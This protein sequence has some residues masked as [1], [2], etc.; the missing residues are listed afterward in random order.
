MRDPSLR[1]EKLETEERE[2][3]A[4]GLPTSFTTPQRPVTPS[5][6]FQ[7]A[8]KADVAVPKT[9]IKFGAKFDP[10][11]YLASMGW[12]G[13]G[14]G[15]SGQG[16]VKPIEVQ[17]RPERAGIAYGGIKEKTSHAK[18]EARRRGE[19]GSSDQ[20]QRQR[21]RS[22]G[23]P[24]KAKPEA[25]AWTKASTPKSRKPKIEHRTYEEIIAE[26]GAL[27]TTH[28]TV[29]KIYDASSGV[30][31]EVEDLASALKAKRVPTSAAT[32]LPELQHNLRLICENNAQSLGALAREGAQL[33]QRRTWLT[34][35]RERA[36]V[37]KKEEEMS[38]QKV[39]GAL[40]VVKRFEAV[41]KRIGDGEVGLDGG[42]SVLEEFTPLIEQLQREYDEKQI[43]QLALDQAV[44]EAITPA[45]RAI[46]CGWKPLEQPR[47][48]SRYL[49]Q[50]KAL[51]P[52][53]DS[54]APSSSSATMTPFDAL[55]WTY[56]MPRVRTCLSTFS[57]RRPASAIDLVEAWRPVLARFMFDNIIDQLIV[58]RLSRSV[59]A[60]DA[61]TSMDAL[62]QI[63]F[64]WLAVLGVERL[65]EVLTQAKQRLRSALK[66]CSISQGPSRGLRDWS[67]LYTTAA[68]WEALLLS[69]LV[70]RLSAYL[71]RR[72]TISAGETQDMTPLVDVLKWSKVVGATVMESVVA[73]DFFAKWLDVLCAWLKS[74]VH[75]WVGM[76]EWYLFWRRWW[77]E[78][79]GG[80]EVGFAI[81]L[82]VINAALDMTADERSKLKT[83]PFAHTASTAPSTPSGMPIRTLPQAHVSLRD[84]LAERLA[85]HDLLLTRSSQVHATGVVGTANIWRISSSPTSRTHA[86]KSSLIYIHDHVVFQHDPALDS[87]CPVSIDHLI[88]SMR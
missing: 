87:W 11:A 14:L 8:R 13:G 37:K 24:E 85:Q 23:E 43:L 29:G 44:V 75:E 32:E 70:P 48:T 63:V 68:E 15:R 18:A 2:M 71:K 20:E 4:S 56:W 55:L 17:V 67:S 34:S 27:P 64:P 52:N 39:R 16:I 77:S 83:P 65:A 6:T 9:T 57:A 84:V 36:I 86:N 60:C 22:Q 30:L 79:V 26:I 21:K 73:S 12:T 58:P 53:Q 5:S 51:L 82:D 72:L 88:N 66:M 31:R 28:S 41:A 80:G 10:S 59:A 50:W 81:G 69:S 46:W 7:R 49:C 40:Q 25:K 38:M 19:A 1:D 42:E 61:P 74:E 54:V 76:D 3:S 33:K 35:E 47:L 45:L 62:E 78:N